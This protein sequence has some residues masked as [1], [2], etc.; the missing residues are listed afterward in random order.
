MK[1]NESKLRFFNLGW[2]SVTP[3]IIA[4]YTAQLAK[5]CSVIDGFAGSGG[6]VIQFSKF[7]NKVFAIDID[8]QKLEICKNNCRVYKC[9]NNISF[10]LHDFLLADKYK[11]EKIS[12]DYIFLSPPWGKLIN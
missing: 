9:E 1:V 4:E 12:A 11:P 5:G 3:E 6:N 2:W 10:I 7:C 8:A